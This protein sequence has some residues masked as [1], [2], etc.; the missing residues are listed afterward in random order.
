MTTREFINNNFDVPSERDRHCS[1]VFADYDGNIYSYGYHYPLLFRVKGLAI[2]NVRGYSNTTAKHI[3]WT[4]DISAVDVEVP[5]D[6]RLQGYT[7]DEL[8]QQL[9]K[10]QQDLL[11]EIR[12]LMFHKKRKDTQVYRQLEYDYN[13]AANSLDWLEGRA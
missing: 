11:K 4:R 6:F 2:R 13:K 3:N 5:R 8:L 7:E 1:S 9:I 10:A 12:G